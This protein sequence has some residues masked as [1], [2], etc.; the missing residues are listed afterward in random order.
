MTYVL[1]FLTKARHFFFGCGTTATIPGET[2][3]GELNV[4]TLSKLNVTAVGVEE[5]L[6]LAIFMV[7]SAR[8]HR[9]EGH[10]GHRL[11]GD[12]GHWLEGVDGHWLEGDTSSVGETLVINTGQSKAL[13]GSAVSVRCL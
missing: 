1:Y 12:T 4:E 9:H 5:S 10:A 2:G 3:N 13:V 11:E 6:S 7:S 8:G